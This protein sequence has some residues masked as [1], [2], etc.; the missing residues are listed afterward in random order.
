LPYQ[1]PFDFELPDYTEVGKT[2]LELAHSPPYE[3]EPVPEMDFPVDQIKFIPWDM[4]DR[5]ELGPDEDDPF[6]QTRSGVKVAP[7]IP[8]QLRTLA[9]G[10]RYLTAN[11]TKKSQY[12]RKYHNKNNHIHF[13][14]YIHFP[15]HRLEVCT[16]PV[17]RPTT[18]AAM[19]G[20]SI[21]KP[22]VTQDIIPI[23]G[24]LDIDDDFR[25]DV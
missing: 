16:M 7:N 4:L 5:P 19:Y 18:S 21:K 14:N 17:R 12:Y 9:K 10:N 20:S 15:H 1:P 23:Q 2:L 8:A 11:Y 24:D 25:F 13:K 22:V 3:N 6:Y